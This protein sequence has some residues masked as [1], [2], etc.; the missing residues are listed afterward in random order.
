[1]HMPQLLP[2]RAVLLALTVLMLGAP[3]AAEVTPGWKRVEIAATASYAWRYVPQSLAPGAAAPV[4]LFFH[5]S[6]ARPEQYRPY[7]APAAERAG[8]VLVL[9]KSADPLGWGTGGDEA[10][11]RESLRAVRAE[12]PVDPRR[13]ALAGHSAGGAWAYLLAYTTR[14][15]YSA[16]FSMAARHYQVGALADPSHKAPIRMYWG[17]ADP[18]YASGAAPLRAQWS[19]L[20]VPWEEDVRAGYDHGTWPPESMEAGFLFL[21]G[22]AHPTG[23]DGETT[24]CAPGPTTLCLGGGRFRVEVAWRDFEGGSG[25]GRV[26]PGASADSG[27]FWFFAPANWELLVKVV[28]GCPVNGRRWVFAAATTNVGYTL[29]VTDT[30]TG[31]QERYENPLGR[32]SPAITDTEAL[33]GCP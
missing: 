16:V 22:K 28:D 29:T 17:V 30:A 2:L 19:R 13:V 31:E 6:G 14:N 11:V 7:V 24:A 9:P 21:A 8:C 25:Q 23:V 4:V 10:T 1:M 12:L 32:S 3:A 5:G 33:A 27:L 15:G 18:N 20:G 26:V